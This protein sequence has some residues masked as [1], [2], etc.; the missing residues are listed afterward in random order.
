MLTKYDMEITF[1][2]A[3]CI[4]LRQVKTILQ[5]SN[6]A[7]KMIRADTDIFIISVVV[8]INR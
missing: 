7:I 4:I 2:G 6:Q 8:V 1:N 3:D 5:K